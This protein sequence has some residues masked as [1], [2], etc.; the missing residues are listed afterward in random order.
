MLQGDQLHEHVAANRKFHALSDG[1]LLTLLDEL[2]VLGEQNVLN[3][4]YKRL[5]VDIN[6][7][8]HIFTLCNLRIV[9]EFFKLP[10]ELTPLKLDFI[11]INFNFLLFECAVD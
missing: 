10:F 11:F 8:I 5:D 3:V 2:G 9:K 1:A 7:E 6:P 4:I